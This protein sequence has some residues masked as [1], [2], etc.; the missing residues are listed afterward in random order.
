MGSSRVV[1]VRGVNDPLAL[2]VGRHARGLLW[3]G[4]VV[5]LLD[6]RV[7]ACLE[8][9]TELVERLV[10]ERLLHLREELLFFLFDVVLDQIEQRLRAGLEALVALRRREQALERELR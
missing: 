6:Q 9:Q 1:T 3:E 5:T 7:E 4:C 8:L 2:L 10:V